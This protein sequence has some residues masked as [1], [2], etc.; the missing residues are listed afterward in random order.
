MNEY[1]RIMREDW[2]SEEC[3]L[4]MLF[5]VSIYALLVLLPLLTSQFEQMAGG[6]RRQELVFIGSNLDEDDIRKALDD[7]LCTDEE[8]DVYRAQVEKYLENAN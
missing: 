8:M 6:D 7:C 3:E 4:T 1:D 2:V 5:C